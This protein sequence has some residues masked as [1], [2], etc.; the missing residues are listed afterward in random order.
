MDLSSSIELLRAA[1]AK[2]E[3]ELKECERLAELASNQMMCTGEICLSSWKPAPTC[4]YSA[5]NA[6]S[7]E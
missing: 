3:I 6:D 4:N 1:T 2:I 5:D 7:L